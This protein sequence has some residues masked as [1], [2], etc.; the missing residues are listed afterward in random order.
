[1]EQPQPAQASDGNQRGGKAR[2]PGGARATRVKNKSPAPI[3]ITAEQI[4]REALDRA[5]EVFKPPKQKIT[6]PEELEDYKFRERKKFEDGIRR[7]RN[8]MAT[9]LKYAEFEA[10]LKEFE[11][12]RSIY[13]RSIDVE[14][15]NP[16]IWIRYAEMEMKHKQIN[17]ARNIWDRAVV[18]LPRVD[19][20][21]LKYSHM[22]FMLGNYPGA[23]QIFER[24]MDWR[25]GEHAW[26]AYI[27]FEL[28]CGETERARTLFQRYVD[29]EPSV[30]SYLRWSKFEEKYGSTEQVRKVFE[31]AIESLGD[32]ANDEKLFIS[33]AR[34]EERAKESERARA[35]YKYALDHIPKKEAQEIYKTWIS[36]EKKN[37]EKEGIEDV[38]LGKRRFQYEEEIKENS[39]N[40]DVWFDYIRLEETYGDLDKIRDVYERAIANMPPATEK[41]FWR[42]YI[43]L[44]VNYALFEELDSKDIEKTRSVYKECINRI[45]HKVFS[46][47]KIWIMF[48]NFEIR[49]KNLQN[50]RQIYGHAIG[51]RPKPKI[52]EA[53]IQ[54]EL[55]LGNVDRCRTI[56]EKFLETSPSHCNAWIKYAHLERD[57]RELD[58]ARGIFEV[59]IGQPHLDSPELLWKVY[60]DF[61][62]E[63]EEYD[64]VREL[65]KRLLERTKHV[66]VWMSFAQFENSISNVEEA[67]KIYSQGFELLKKNDNKEEAVMLIDSWKEFEVKTGDQEQIKAV[68]K[69]MPKRIIKKRPLVM[70]DG[71]EAGFEEFYDYIFPGEEKAPGLAILEMARQWKKQANQ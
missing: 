32:E 15:R 35:I 11:R 66:K 21:W 70:E 60:I 31:Q 51:L 67:R 28:R 46:F 62:T 58:R 17:A 12:A 43:Y 26:N 1:M 44:W 4:L 52:F 71:S 68:E 61:E 54:L 30:K 2:G 59:A 9:W 14:Y 69:K 42:R 3:Q 47:S 49:Q 25:P 18:L 20:F 16:Q 5:D 33:F 6:D 27:R 64:K 13:E 63:Q 7:V 34:N 29:A 65:Y 37:G 55:Q 39:K 40:Y 41:R 36:F 48:A 57:L 53:Y 50:A 19:Q 45:P 56:Y 10:G 23:R 8:N 38:I 24:W 22:E